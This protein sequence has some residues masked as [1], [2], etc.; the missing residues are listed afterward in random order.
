M[1]EEERRIFARKNNMLRRHLGRKQVREIVADQLKD[2][3]SWA[4]LRIDQVLGV[5]SKTVQS[6]R[7]GLER[8]SEIPKFD[9][10]IGADG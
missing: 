8:T 2:T 10:L 7:H 6:V 1:S 3:P 5:D 4:N 9:K